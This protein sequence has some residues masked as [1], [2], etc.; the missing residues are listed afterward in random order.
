MIPSS[1]CR[2]WRPDRSGPAG[3]RGDHTAA[4]PRHGTRS[5]LVIHQEET[6]RIENVPDIYEDDAGHA[7]VFPP[8]AKGCAGMR[9]YSGSV[10]SPVHRGTPIGRCLY[11]D[12]DHR[13][14]GT[15]V[16][17]RKFR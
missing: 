7:L 16:S 15:T 12:E 13:I 11:R 4:T 1:A 17:Y 3:E 8:H 2:S 6:R 10:V 9:P 5:F 14:G